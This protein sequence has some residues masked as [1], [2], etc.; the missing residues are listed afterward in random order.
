MFDFKNVTDAALSA[1]TPKSDDYVHHIAYHDAA[2]NRLA[3]NQLNAVKTSVFLSIA[4]FSLLAATGNFLIVLPWFTVML[5]ILGSLFGYF[6][7]LR[8][9]RNDATTGQRKIVPMMFVYGCCWA[10]LPFVIDASG[11]P[12]HRLIASVTAIVIYLA[13]LIDQSAVRRIAIMC[14]TPVALTVGYLI[15]TAHEQ[16]TLALVGCSVL[17]LIALGHYSNLLL[18]YIQ[19]MQVSEIQG[20]NLL[21]RVTSSGETIALALEAGSACV[22]EIDFK[23]MVVKRAHGVEEVFGNGFNPETLL[24]PRMTPISR[25]HRRA[26]AQLMR[27]LSEGKRAAQG[28]FALIRSDGTKRYVHVSGRASASLHNYCCI[29]VADVTAS[30]AEREALR[31]A[32][33]ER[34]TAFDDHANL[35]EKV[36]TCVWGVDFENGAII[37][38][39]RFGRIFGF[40]PTFDHVTGIDTTYF[41]ESQLDAFKVVMAHCLSTG[42]PELIESKF[43]G[44]DGRSHVTRSLVSVFSNSGNGLSRALFAT[45]DLTAEHEKAGLLSAAMAKAEQQTAMLEMTLIT[46]KGVTF[47]MDF[48]NQSFHFDNA[49]DQIWDWEMSFEEGLAGLFAIEADRPRVLALSQAAFQRGY[50]SEPVIYRANRKDGQLRW[51]QAIGNYSRTPENR[52][53]ALTCIAFDVTG[54][55]EAARELQKSKAQ[56]EENTEKLKLALAC[57]NGVTMEFNLETGE[58]ICEQDIVKTWGFDGSLT[59]IVAGKHIFEEDRALYLATVRRALKLGRYEKPLVHRVKR[60]DGVEMWV[61]SIGFIK[62]NEAG[63]ARSFTQ[64]V[65]DVTQREVTAREMEAAR[66][67]AESSANRLDFA[68]ATNMSFVVELDHVAQV[69][70]GGERCK[71]LLGRIPKIEDFYTFEWVRSDHKERVR[72]IIF[73]NKS[74][75]VPFTLDFPV[76]PEFGD[77]RWLEV[78]NVTTRDANG[79]A[80]RSVMLWSDV[81]ERKKAIIDFEASLER[82]QDS[83][84]ARRTLLAAIGATHGF[85]IDVDDYVATNTAKLSAPGSGLESLH[86]RLGTILAEID[87][88]DASLTEAVYAL[89]QSK[90]GAEAASQSKSQFLANMSHELRTPLNAVIGYAEIIEEDLEAEGH[91]QSCKDA[92]KI[93]SAA[94]HLLALINEILDLSKIEAGK[95]ELSSV[96]TDLDAL[97]IDVSSMTAQLAMEKHNE[98]IIDVHGLGSADVDDTKVRQCLFNLLSNAC[99]FTQGGTV[100]LEGRRDGNVLHFLVQDTGIGM[101]Q[102][103]IGKLFQSF[104]Q[105]D[106]STTRKY[107]GTGLGLMITRELARLMGGD[108]TVTSIMGIGS[109]FILS[110]NVNEPKNA[111]S[112]AA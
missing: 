26:C 73:D 2:V 62:L 61:E 102:E 34:E 72:S 98:L 15:A 28:E 70:Y 105:A 5:A 53:A 109:T 103:Q 19:R 67:Q 60:N 95:M 97:V 31:L 23:E 85:E 91:V 89:E 44:P 56:A 35:V 68:L 30:V 27:E 93:R 111:A 87:A 96:C 13:I 33:L 10:W 17:S 46:A 66:V 24:D 43:V 16:P 82:A 110:I 106:S 52:I 29:L 88:R 14:V 74:N 92:R 3:T 77:G 58:I 54:R 101:S 63:R 50:F 99:K 40:I 48:A 57:A 42:T 76:A 108:V 4:I 107:G 84:A 49:T 32:K 71:A 90:Q 86:I 1:S 69:V 112:I 20:R 75:D 11:V 45:T 100:R 55:E 8:K 47:E 36:G 21:E 38:G 12:D 39:E 7:A 64:I 83:L 22:I 37:G 81:T 51:V 59:D 6:Y 41:A 25:E 94:K 104:V 18:N 9:R 79:F 80:L 65:F 78:R